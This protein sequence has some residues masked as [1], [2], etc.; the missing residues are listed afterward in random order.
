V[1][2]YMIQLALSSGLHVITTASPKSFALMLKLGVD[3]DAVF[4]YRDSEV[5][6]KIR[7]YVARS[8]GN[9][10]GALRW[11][12]DCMSFGETPKLVAECLGPEP[13]TRRS[14]ASGGNLKRRSWRGSRHWQT[15]LKARP[16]SG[17]YE[18]PGKDVKGQFGVVFTLLGKVRTVAWSYI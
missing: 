8:R 2:Q 18:V 12:V 15:K 10:D 1:G 14:I 4:D 16:L 9:R 5:V 11:A 6:K 7:D 17:V 13:E 3:P